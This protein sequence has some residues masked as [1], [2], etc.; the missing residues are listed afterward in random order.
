M[1]EGAGAG[2]GVGVLGAIVGAEGGSDA[3]VGVLMPSGA[4]PTRRLPMSALMVRNSVETSTW[5]ALGTE[6]GGAT[7]A[8]DVGGAG[9]AGG[10]MRG[11]AGGGIAGR[12]SGA[13]DTGVSRGAG[14]GAV[15]CGGGVAPTG[16]G[17][18]ARWGA[19]GRFGGGADWGAGFC[20]ARSWS[21]ALIR[22][23]FGVCGWSGMR[24]SVN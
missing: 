21:I 8:M 23:A 18:G 3:D 6:I 15:G 4:C 10:V 11:G 22:A 7:G 12:G 17:V 1:T 19:V 14:G 9:G 16:R 24:E 2:G 20:A 13:T 5:G